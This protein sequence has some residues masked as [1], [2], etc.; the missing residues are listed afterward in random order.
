MVEVPHSP[1]EVAWPPLWAGAPLP[2][3]APAPNC[4]WG[5]GCGTFLVLGGVRGPRVVPPIRVRGWGSCPGE[6]GAD[7]TGD[8]AFVCRHT[9][10]RWLGPRGDEQGLVR[11]IFW[12]FRSFP[13][14]SWETGTWVWPAPPLPEGEAQAG[15][16]SLASAFP[17]A[18]TWWAPPPA[19]H[20]GGAPAPGRLPGWPQRPRPSPRAQVGSGVL[21]RPFGM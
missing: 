2:E 3:P 9:L 5:F 6:E 16:R 18:L 13:A 14:E 19:L 21:G 1:L 4:S 20:R 15:V 11:L 8:A 12:V 10:P 17:A 7:D